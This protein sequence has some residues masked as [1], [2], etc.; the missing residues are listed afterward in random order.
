MA[1][2][3]RVSAT[4]QSHRPWRTEGD[5]PGL[6]AVIGLQT[7][8]R[9]PLLDEPSGA[10]VI[11]VLT[12]RQCDQEQ[13]DQGDQ[14]AAGPVPAPRAAGY[15]LGAL[16]Q[17][18]PAADRR[19]GQ[20]DEQIG[21]VLEVSQRGR[22]TALLAE[23]LADRRLDVGFGELVVGVVAV[24]GASQRAVAGVDLDRGETQ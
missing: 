16:E 4:Q 23:Q 22:R 5:E 3:V 2:S 8:D 14:Q 7:L 11:G 15:R 9:F 19:V 21:V 12:P 18:P 20:E 1:V 10:L 6:V 13:R 24:E 17:Q